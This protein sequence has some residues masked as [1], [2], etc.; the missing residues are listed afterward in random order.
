M[1]KKEHCYFVYLIASRSRTLYC[2]VTN[3]SE[4]RVAQHKEG[5]FGGFTS[6]YR[7][8]RLVW[9]ERFQYIEDAIMREK[10]IKGWRREKKVA[11]I[12]EQNPTWE[13]LSERWRQEVVLGEAR[14]GSLA[15]PTPFRRDP[16]KQGPR[17]QRSG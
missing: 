3:D 1:T 5:A 16:A 15:L 12:V 13:D 2:G 17:A 7:C 10:E 9:F 4:R 8:T 11:L 14:S 6:Q